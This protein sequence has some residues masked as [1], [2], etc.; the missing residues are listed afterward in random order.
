MT[1]HT[2][3]P[4]GRNIKPATKYSTIYAGDAP[5]HVHICHLATNGLTPE[6]IEGNCNLITAAPKLLE[7]LEIAYNM[8]CA[9][10][11][12]IGTPPDDK[13]ALEKIRVIIAAAKGE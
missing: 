1:Q 6:E 3:G 11:A 13:A 12:N 8:A 10:S 9:G 5:N 2:K 4:W 7:A